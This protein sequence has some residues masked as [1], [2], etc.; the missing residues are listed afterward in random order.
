[1]P[2]APLL[3]L[4]VIACSPSSP[5]A[6]PV[7][8]ARSAAASDARSAGAAPQGAC[9]S[10]ADCGWD[11]PCVPTRCIPGGKRR[12]S[13]VACEESAPEPGRC[14]CAAGACTLQAK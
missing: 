3:A 14:V 10:D 7:P 8:T 5:D 11:E 6:V 2:R 12:S 9:S 1:M 4:L 13:G